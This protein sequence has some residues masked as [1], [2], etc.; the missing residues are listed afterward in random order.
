MKKKLGEFISNEMIEEDGVLLW[1]TRIRASAVI[2]DDAQRLLLVRQ[3]EDLW[4]LPGGGVEQGETILE[5]LRRE[6][7][8]ETGLEIEP[9]RLLWFGNEISEEYKTLYIGVT[10]VAEPA[11]GC[12][13]NSE[14]DCRYYSRHELAPM[15][16]PERLKDELWQA[17]E[18]SKSHDPARLNKHMQ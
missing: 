2:L 4:V 3:V 18:A 8:E 10:F 7:W 5:G 12:I 11:G 17:V 1:R 13:G 6:L 9:I 14:H 16:V 15:N